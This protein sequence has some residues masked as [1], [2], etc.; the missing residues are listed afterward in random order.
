MWFSFVKAPW[1]WKWVS[2]GLAV[3]MVVGGIWY[4]GQQA[5]FSRGYDRAMDNFQ[6]ELERVN[7]SWQA[8]VRDRDGLWQSEIDRAFNQL[9][10]QFNKYVEA[11]RREAEL[12]AEM[13]VLESTL[14]EIQNVYQGSDF[15]QCSVSPTFDR[16]L[17]DAH[18]AATTRPD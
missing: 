15:G 3:G 10:E 17:N 1:L 6:R 2:G 4:A 11:E 5:G 8:T 18:R 7:R 12:L 13:A 9:Q 14:K 16:L